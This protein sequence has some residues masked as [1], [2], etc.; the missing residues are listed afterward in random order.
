[1]L[2]YVMILSVF[3]VSMRPALAQGPTAAEREACAADVKKFCADVKPGGG[4]IRACLSQ[5][6][7]QLSDSCRDAV[8]VHSKPK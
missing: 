5:N 6:A 8:E 3:V 2:R 7:N 4:R 1:M